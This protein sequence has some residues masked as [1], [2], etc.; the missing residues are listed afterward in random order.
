[1]TKL[2][3]AADFK[4]PL[5]AEVIAETA[6]DAVR[7]FDGNTAG[8]IV[9]MAVDHAENVEAGIRSAIK[10]LDE[11][12]T[13]WLDDLVF[14]LAN[15]FSDSE[16]EDGDFRDDY[17]AIMHTV[18]GPCMR[19]VAPGAIKVHFPKK[20]HVLVDRLVDEFVREEEERPVRQIAEAKAGK[21]VFPIS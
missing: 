4:F 15:Q 8:R 9:E 11:A 21:L 18:W 6:A 3:T 19:A 14:D 16:V 5:P 10:D 17:D 2:L 13:V 1:M 20:H 7:C 12:I